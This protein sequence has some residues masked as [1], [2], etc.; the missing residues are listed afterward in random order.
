MIQAWIEVI[1]YAIARGMTR[2][3]LDVIKE[4]S[5]QIEEAPN[6]D[7]KARALRMR[8]AVERVL[9]AS[10]PVDNSRP[11]NPPPSR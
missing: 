7:D 3:Y 6:A 2:G 9:A 8:A 10:T 1:F 4:R 11:D 5:T